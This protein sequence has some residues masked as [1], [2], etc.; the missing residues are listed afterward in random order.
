MNR[1]TENRLVEIIRFLES[2]EKT[3]ME[4]A[5]AY[6]DDIHSQIAYEVGYLNS[7]IRQ[8]TH[9]LKGLIEK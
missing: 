7:S 9:E 6:S 3:A 4:S 1:E 2:I 5:R 8:V